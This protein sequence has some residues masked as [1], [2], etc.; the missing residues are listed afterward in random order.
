MEAIHNLFVMQGTMLVLFLAGALLARRGTVTPEFR[1][2]L[3]DFILTVI[4]PCNIVKSFLIRFDD[5][6]FQSCME[7]FLVSCAAQFLSIATGNLVFGRVEEGRREPLQYATQVNNAGFLGNPIVEGIYGIQGQ[8]F[9][10]VYLIPQ[11]VLMWT[12]GMACY[13]GVRGKGVLKKLMKHPCILAVII[14]MV[15]MLTQISLPLWVEKPLNMVGSC[16]TALSLLVIGCVLGEQKPGSRIDRQIL[17]YCG[18]RL[19][20]IP[21]IV[22]VACLLLK[23]DPM[24]IRISV[25]LAGMPA[26]VTTAMLAS[27]YRRDEVFAVS[28]LFWSTVASVVTVPALCLLTETLVK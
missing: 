18:L 17:R 16:N 1:K 2:A 11:R 23:L 8:L 15:L 24:V 20:L 6:I 12:V 26:G 14:G 5:R 13:S 3:T 21:G 22:L 19:L 28:L 7:I 9:A 27:Q 10:S 4:L 25:I